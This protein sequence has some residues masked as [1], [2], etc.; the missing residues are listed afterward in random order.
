MTNPNNLPGSGNLPPDA[1]SCP[2][3]VAALQL[4]L[5]TFG[6]KNLQVWFAQVEAILDPNHI[7]A[8]TSRFRHLL[9]NRSPEVAQ[10]VA[11]VITAPLGSAPYQRLKHCI[12]ERTTQSDSVRLQHLLADRR[13]CQEFNSMRQLQRTSNV[14]S[15]DALLREQRLPHSTS[16]LLQRTSPSTASPTS[17]IGSKTRLL[18]RP[19]PSLQHE[20]PQSCPA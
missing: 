4:R 10:E 18:L 20:S 13:P 19:P 8:E 17:L 5:P 16:W 6:H 1:T 15:N 2:R 7:T 11:D 12:L 14:D 3:D 9:C